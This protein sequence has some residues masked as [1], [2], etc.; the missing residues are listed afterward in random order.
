MGPKRK[1][2][3][4]ISSN[5]TYKKPRPV[6]TTTEEEFYAAAQKA[7]DRPPTKAE[8]EKIEKIRQERLRRRGEDEEFAAADTQSSTQTPTRDF[9]YS[10]DDLYS[11]A[12][13]TTPPS[14]ES[15]WLPPNQEMDSSEQDNTIVEVSPTRPEEPEEPPPVSNRDLN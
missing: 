4:I 1:L 9:N 13:T 11:D 14:Q 12:M 6:N 10:S 15:P 5:L 2:S 8:R 3:P 7:A